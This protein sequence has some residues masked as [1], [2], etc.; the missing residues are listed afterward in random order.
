MCGRVLWTLVHFQRMMQTL[1]HPLWL[2]SQSISSHAVSQ[3]SKRIRIVVIYIAWRNYVYEWEKVCKTSV[4]HAS[5]ALTSAWH[6]TPLDIVNRNGEKTCFDQHNQVI[7]SLVSNVKYKY[8]TL[9]I[10]DQ[11]NIRMKTQ[12]SSV[13][14]S[15][16]TF[17]SHIPVLL[18]TNMCV[19]YF[20]KAQNG[21]IVCLLLAICVFQPG[22]FPIGNFR[23]IVHRYTSYISLDLVSESRQMNRFFDIPM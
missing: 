3:Q 9:S 6:W 22:F 13:I 10:I 17:H 8:S 12:L 23:N 18:D 16:I 5:R 11:W 21:L 14:L 2:K 15:M 4:N 20:N 7:I 19:W 1:L